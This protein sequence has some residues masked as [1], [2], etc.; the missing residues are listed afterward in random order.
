MI[1]G[2]EVEIQQ[3]FDFTKCGSSSTHKGQRLWAVT[4][5]LRCPMRTRPSWGRAGRAACQRL[6]QA[7]ERTSG[8]AVAQCDDHQLF[9]LRFRGLLRLQPR[10]GT[11][12]NT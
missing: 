9:L 11:A 8:P 1:L 12:W 7:Q 6:R 4:S 2:D 10:S 3:V 5:T